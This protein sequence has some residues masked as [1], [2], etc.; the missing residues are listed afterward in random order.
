MYHVEK[1]DGHMAQVNLQAYLNEYVPPH[2]YKI[3]SISTT[4]E[5]T[6]KNMVIM[7]VYRE[8]L[9]GEQ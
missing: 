9:P 2:H 3:E 5:P 8:L 7:L 4:Y 6:F 1:F